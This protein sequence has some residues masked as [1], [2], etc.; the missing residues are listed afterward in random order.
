MSMRPFRCYCL[1]GLFIW[2]WTNVVQFYKTNVALLS[3]IWYNIH[4]G[5]YDGKRGIQGY[6]L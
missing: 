1:G 4:R 6:N 2:K 5:V 3:A